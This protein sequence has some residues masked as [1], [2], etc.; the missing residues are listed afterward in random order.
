MNKKRSFI[1]ISIILSFICI[2]PFHSFPAEENKSIYTIQIASHRDVEAAQKQFN[3][4]AQ[5]FNK[6]MLEYLRIEKIGKFYSLRLGKFN[7]NSDAKKFMAS[8]KSELP[9]SIIMKAYF[10]ED[11]IVR[12]YKPQNAVGEVKTLQT[13]VS[14]DVTKKETKETKTPVVEKTDRKTDEIKKDIPIEDKIASISSFVQNKD[15]NSALE[16]IQKEITEQ[17]EHPELNAWYGTVLLKTDKPEEALTY[18][19]KAAELSPSEPD[20]QNGVGY[21]LFY[22]DKPDK[23]VDAFNKAISLEP[24]HI[25]AIAGLGI[26]YAK[27]GNK[28]KA[29]DIYNKLKNLDQVSA[30]KLLKII[31]DP[32]L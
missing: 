15:Y 22:L 14:K 10:L 3:T 6:K 5:N 31:E 18:L 23:A 19:K 16:I 32:R 26:V 8:V 27:S 21:C 12:I 11:R 4:I 28:K 9:S 13:R 25:D 1:I 30:D 24:G 20:Y 17:P 7:N 2:I 29:I